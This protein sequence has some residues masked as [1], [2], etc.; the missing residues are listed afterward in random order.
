[1][2]CLFYKLFNRLLRKLVVPFDF[3]YFICV[4]YQYAIINWNSMFLCKTY[5]VFMAFT[6]GQI[7]N[8]LI[9]SV[10]FFF[11]TLL[12]VLIFAVYRGYIWSFWCCFIFW[13]TF[14]KM[15]WNIDNWS[16][17]SYS[18]DI[19]ES[20]NPVGKGLLSTSP[21]Q[22]TLPEIPWWIRQPFIVRK[23]STSDLALNPALRKSKT[24]TNT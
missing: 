19:S 10:S 17:H 21:V 8:W 20:L 18:L 23:L 7:G 12:A 14:Q 24:V 1:V 5:V 16:C 15:T 13:A 22:R 11:F 9:T 6:Q 4:V 3:L 2:L